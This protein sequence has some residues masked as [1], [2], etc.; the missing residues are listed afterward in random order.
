MPVLTYPE[1]TQ[2]V[3]RKSEP[4]FSIH[5]LA[6]VIIE[7]V[8]R[9]VPLVHVNETLKRIVYAMKHFSDQDVFKTCKKLANDSDFWVF[10]RALVNENKEK[11]DFMKE[12][13]ELG[14]NRI[15]STDFETERFI[16]NSNFHKQFSERKL[17]SMSIE[18]KISNYSLTYV[19]KP[20]FDQQY[21]IPLQ[22]KNNELKVIPSKGAMFF[23]THSLC[24]FERI[25]RF[26][27]NK[28]DND[29][30]GQEMFRY[31][32]YIISQTPIHR[33]VYLIGLAILEE[34]LIYVELP[35]FSK[36][37][38]PAS[39]LSFVALSIAEK[40]HGYGKEF[41]NKWK[42]FTGVSHI[43]FDFIVKAWRYFHDKN[44]RSAGLSSWSDWVVKYKAWFALSDTK[45]KRC[46]VD[47]FENPYRLP[48]DAAC[49]P[50][51]ENKKT[52]MFP[53]LKADW[54]KVLERMSSLRTLCDIIIQY[55]EEVAGE[56]FANTRPFVNDA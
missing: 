49:L 34:I 1:Q 4:S 25:K 20:V 18:E 31:L 52:V 24:I 23:I 10:L 30:I 14:Q 19:L 29:R 7:V 15:E 54:G 28:V 45:Y 44:T 27:S 2:I 32:N 36:T 56:R 37:Y 42:T 40:E 55:N 11:L 39:L 5:S 50:Y 33:N 21:L 6:S 47:Y 46:S 3:F 9:T 38:N 35:R 13:S 22:T 16:P 17:S 53:A 48:I 51:F 26:S 43:D 8:C 12:L 41:E